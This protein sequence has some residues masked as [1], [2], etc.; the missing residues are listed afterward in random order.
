M[1]Y[2]DKDRNLAMRALLL[3]S[4]AALLL[5]TGTAR[6][7]DPFNCA[8]RQERCDPSDAEDNN[9]EKPPSRVTVTPPLPPGPPP[10]GWVYGPY[11]QCADPPRCSI[12][13]VTV[14]ADGLNVRVAP[15]GPVVMALVNGTT[16][17]PLQRQGDW[18]LIAPACD[19]TPTWVWSWTAPVQLFRCWEYF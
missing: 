18:F 19:L 6:A 13:A 8:P 14:G 12:G 5:A 15:N 11:T 16:F 4:V 10:L 17:I 7:A 1:Q 2:R 9:W 3:A